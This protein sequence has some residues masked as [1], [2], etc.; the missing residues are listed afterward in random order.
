MLPCGITGFGKARRY[1]GLDLTLFDYIPD[2]RFTSR[3]VLG[4]RLARRFSFGDG[5]VH[6]SNRYVRTIGFLEE[7]AARRVLHTGAF[8]TGNPSGRW[9]NNPFTLKV[10]TAR[11]AF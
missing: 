10:A 5:G 6:F 3:N 4:C 2:N 7:Q 1:Q 9:F 8:A 11:L